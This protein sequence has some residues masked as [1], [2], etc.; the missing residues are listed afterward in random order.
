M[1]TSTTLWRDPALPPTLSPGAWSAGWL[2]IP[3]HP[4]PPTIPCRVWVPSV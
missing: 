1:A 3:P 2:P 4:G